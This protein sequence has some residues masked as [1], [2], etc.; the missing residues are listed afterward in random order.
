M[1]GHSAESSPDESANGNSSRPASMPVPLN[2][3]ASR[4]LLVASVAGCSSF[5]RHR[6]ER[7]REHIARSAPRKFYDTVRAGSGHSGDVNGDGVPDLA[8]AAPFQDGDF[9]STQSSYGKPQNVGKI[10]IL[11]GSTLSVLNELND[12]EFELV[13][14]QHFGGQLGSSLTTVADLNGMELPTCSRE[15]RITLQTR[16]PTRRSS[17]QVRPSFSAAKMAPCFLPSLIR[18]PKRMAKWASPWLV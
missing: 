4:P 14:P 18:R 13:Q 2:H 6:T 10:F 15:F 9:V 3:D 5:S 8:V 16:I 17:M 1:D 7:K 12:P 11:D